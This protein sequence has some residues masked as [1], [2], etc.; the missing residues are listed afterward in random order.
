MF[1]KL[2]VPPFGKKS[3][4]PDSIEDPIN[5]ASVWMISTNIALPNDMG[6][7]RNSVKIEKI[8]FKL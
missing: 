4:V 1:C 5:P 6:I 8:S 2:R 7:V 3:T